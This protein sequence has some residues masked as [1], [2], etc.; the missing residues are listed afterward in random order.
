MPPRLR[1]TRIRRMALRGPPYDGRARVPAGR[2]P[3]YPGGPTE[4]VRGALLAGADQRLTVRLSVGPPDPILGIMISSEVAP[5]FLTVGQATARA[6]ALRANERD[7]LGRTFLVFGPAGAG[8]GCAR[9]SLADRRWPGRSPAAR[10]ARLRDP[11]LRGRRVLQEP[12]QPGPAQPVEHL[13]E[14]LRPVPATRAPAVERLG[15]GR[16]PI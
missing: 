9:T 8:K 15:L 5:G 1:R 7:R 10:S 13:P 3:A 11:H 12:L 4:H 16:T 14:L 6:V 2:Q